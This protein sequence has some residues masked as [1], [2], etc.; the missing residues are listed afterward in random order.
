MVGKNKIRQTSVIAKCGRIAKK[1]LVE[2]VIEIA[3]HQVFA[4]TGKRTGKA[5]YAVKNSFSRLHEPESYIIAYCL[6]LGKGVGPLVLHFRPA[7]NSPHLRITK[8]LHHF[9]HRLRLQEAVGINKYQ[10]VKLGRNAPAASA[11]RLPIL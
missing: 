10:Q 3:Q 5:R 2:P 1:L 9:P 11:W 6:H 8:R 4:I 7:G